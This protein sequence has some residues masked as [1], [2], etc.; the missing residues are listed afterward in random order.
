VNFLSKLVALKPGKA[1]ERMIRDVMNGKAEGA[2]NIKQSSAD[3]H[4]EQE[5]LTGLSGRVSFEFNLAH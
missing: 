1:L 5:H 4:S 3:S 2:D